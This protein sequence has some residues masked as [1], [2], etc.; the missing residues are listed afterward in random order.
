MIS[1]GVPVDFGSTR[2]LGVKLR[3]RGVNLE[4]I[5]LIAYP[6]WNIPSILRN[7]I[8]LRGGSF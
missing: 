1:E 6:I 2:P 8:N 7:E 5:N 4:I 3:P